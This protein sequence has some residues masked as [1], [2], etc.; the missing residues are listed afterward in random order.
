MNKEQISEAISG[1]DDRFISEAAQIKKKNT[2]YKYGSAAAVLAVLIISGIAFFGSDINIPPV[3]PDSTTETSAEN[4]NENNKI[5]EIETTPAIETVTE[6]SHFELPHWEDLVIPLRYGEATLGEITYST[7]NTEIPAENVLDFLGNTEMQGYDIYTDTTYKVNAEIYSIRSIS[8]ACAVAVK[9]DGGEEYYIYVNIWYE[10]ENLGEFIS[11]LD[12]KNTVIF[13]KAYIN[14]YEYTDLSSTHKQIVYSDFDDSVIW[15][16]LED[17]LTAKNIE[18]NHPYDRI[19]VETN[20]PLLGYKNIS[21]CITPDGYIITNILN[22]QKCFFIGTEKFNEFDE[23]LKNNV[24]FKENTTVYELNP[25]GSIPG[26]EDVTEQSTPGYNPD[27]QEQIV[28]PYN[29]ETD[30]APPEAD[31][32]GE[33]PQD[34]IAEETTRID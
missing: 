17:V 4:A 18:Y 29:P 34:F 24:P 10:P 19:D 6:I 33:I 1:I 5:P 2:I 31:T 26:K 28:P 22:T 15:D 25:D 11:D 14:I 13:G 9:I 21:F 7:Q 3:T 8:T 16:M 27:A 32:D 20:L 23:Y 30:A 12:L